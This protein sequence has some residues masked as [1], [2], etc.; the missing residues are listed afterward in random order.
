VADIDSPMTADIANSLWTYNPETGDLCWRNNHSQMKA[1]DKAGSGG[2]RYSQ[3]GAR[4][5]GKTRL[6]MV[7]RIAWLMMTGDWPRGEVDHIDGNTA[8]NSWA[9]LRLVDRQL[10]VQNQRRAHKNSTH[11]FMG[12]T[13]SKQHAKWRARIYVDG[14]KRHLGLFTTPEEA[15]SCYV[16]AKRLFH[17]GCTI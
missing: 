13:Y 12:V 9:N 17:P 11:G 6:Y 16:E 4:L 7:H 15:H 2:R 3:V 10:N 8:N 5:N 1:G 14:H